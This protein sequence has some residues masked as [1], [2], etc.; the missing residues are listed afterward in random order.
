M[1][2]PLREGRRE[3]PVLALTGLWPPSQG[4]QLSKLKIEV[5]PEPTAGVPCIPRTAFG[6]RLCLMLIPAWLAVARSH[7]ASIR[8]R[9][10]PAKPQPGRAASRLAPRWSEATPGGFCILATP[11]AEGVRVFLTAV[12]SE[13]LPDHNTFP[14]NGASP[15]GRLKPA[16]TARP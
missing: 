13:R 5:L 10:R 8:A 3:A 7:R 16:T 9:L 11:H 14:K 15:N 6:V 1:V 4:D 2:L 12:L